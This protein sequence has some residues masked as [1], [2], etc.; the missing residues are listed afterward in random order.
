MSEY[1]K[2]VKVRKNAKYSLIIFLRD[3]FLIDQG[4]R[5]KYLFFD[6]YFETRNVLALCREPKNGNGLE[7]ITKF[8]LRE[9]SLRSLQD[10]FIPRFCVSEST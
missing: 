3:Q 1:T 6:S 5:H 7:L 10:L 2:H 8:S 9:N 4:F